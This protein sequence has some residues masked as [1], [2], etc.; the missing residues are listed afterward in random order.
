MPNWKMAA[1][2]QPNIAP[3]SSGRDFETVYFS[4]V[5]PSRTVRADNFLVLKLSFN[6]VFPAKFLLGQ[7]VWSPNI[8]V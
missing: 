3:L 2:I 7:T 1:K 6:E 4:Y 8:F 5:P